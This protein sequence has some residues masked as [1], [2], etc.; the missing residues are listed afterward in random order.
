MEQPQ[1]TGYPVPV[2]EEDL[3]LQRLWLA[4]RRHW[5]PSLL[6]FGATVALAT[7]AAFT[8]K[9]YYEAKGKLLLRADQSSALQGLSESLGGLGGL[10]NLGT[11]GGSLATEAEVIQSAPIAQKAIEALNLQ[12]EEGQPI[13][14]NSFLG[15]LEVASVSG[16]DVLE[17]IYKSEDPEESAAVVNQLMTLYLSDREFNNRAAATA[18]RTFIEKQLPQVQAKLYQTETAL[19]QFKEQ[20]QLVVPDEEAKLAV[21][22]LSE[23]SQ[24][25]DQARAELS[26]ADT[27]SGQ[28][29]TK[30]G[31]QENDAITSSALSQSVGVQQALEELQTVETELAKQRS[32][33]QESH[34]VVLDLRDKQTQLK[35]VL[36]DRVGNVVGTQQTTIPDNLQA[37]TLQQTLTQEL[38][39]SEV[40]RLELTSRINSFN[41]IQ[42]AFQQ[43][44]RVIPQLEQM[45]RNLEREREIAQQTYTTLVSRLQEARVQEAKTAADN[46]ALNQARILEA[47]AIPED[48]TSR[49]NLYLALG[50]LLGGALAGAT[51]LI[52]ELLDPSIRTAEEAREKWGYAVLGTIPA[53]EGS[54]TKQ[55]R[56]LTPVAEA[57]P[58]R[59]APR[60]LSSEAYRKLQ[61]NLQFLDS[62]H[63]LKTI[64][65]TSAVPKE[66]K[67]TVS[68]N[69][70]MTMAQRGHR[71]LLV[72]ADLRCPTQHQIWQLSNGVGLSNFVSGE[73]SFADAVQSLTENLDVLTAG[74]L[75]E[76]PSSFLDSDRLSML[77]EE[78]ANYYDCVILDTAPLAVAADAL[79]LGKLA[80]GL[81]VVVQPGVVKSVN[82]TVA[83]ES[84][85]QSN[86]KVLGLVING[87]EPEKEYSQYYSNYQNVSGGKNNS[88][89]HKL[90][91]SVKQFTERL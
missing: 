68:A 60:S 58:V 82:A 42:T 53:L 59:D 80:D 41:Q 4:L 62:G 51:T 39:Q 9:P 89:P 85:E 3:D 83:K 37:G 72:D 70:A 71:V 79:I 29:R 75:P 40:K 28:L 49:K 91:S 50:V 11:K 1:L 27:R 69:L 20:N 67:S 21:G 84:L 36:T 31:M 24:A 38:V 76:N 19:R 18:L 15:N 30:L 16:T 77:T 73:A 81:L 23:L 13:K 90:A 7:L 26:A 35:A 56:S 8:Q 64:V 47:A 61:V 74:R 12:T 66:G 55:R 52:L 46:Q 44:M 5:R 57:L 65:V 43:Q 54:G 45:G 25:I 32:V 10:V 2:E 63:S 22:R 48:P 33:Y 17:L 34:P 6:V 78:V 14:V 88:I 86:Q 87:V